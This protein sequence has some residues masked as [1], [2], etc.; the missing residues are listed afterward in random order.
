[1]DSADAVFAWADKFSDRVHAL[2]EL[3]RT[4]MQLHT[5]Q[6]T[7]GGCNFW[8]TRSCPKEVHNNKRGTYSGP[9]SLSIK[10]GQFSMSASTA[11]SCEV[12]EA[13]IAQLLEKLEPTV[14]HGAV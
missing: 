2:D 7:C 8:M 13:K 1:M 3:K 12:G 14:R 5:A 6:T 9:S 11:K 10:C 4:R